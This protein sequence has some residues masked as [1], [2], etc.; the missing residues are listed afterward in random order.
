VHKLQPIIDK[1][2]RGAL[3]G[4]TKGSIMPTYRISELGKPLSDDP[5]YEDLSEEVIDSAIAKSTYSD[6]AYGI[7]KIDGES[8]DIQYIVYAGLLW[9][10]E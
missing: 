1:S 8:K 9:C 6:Q 7:F 4:L 10:W 2:R 5:I 3:A